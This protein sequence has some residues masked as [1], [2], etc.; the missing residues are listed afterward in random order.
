MFAKGATPVDAV[1]LGANQVDRI[2]KGADAVYD[3]ASGGD[4]AVTPQIR[5][6]SLTVNASGSS[7]TIPIPAGAV[8]GDTI[9]AFVSGGYTPSLMSG[10]T[11]VNF[12]TGTNWNGRIQ[13]KVLTSADIAAGTQTYSFNNTYS[14]SIWLVVMVG[15]VG[16]RSVEATRNGGGATTRTV[17]E[18]D[19]TPQVGDL[20][21]FFG[22]TR[23]LSTTVV[24]LN[25]GTA[26]TDNMMA[27]NVAARGFREVL[28][29]AGSQSA[30]VSYT[31]AGNGDYQAL[32][33]LN[34]L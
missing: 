28:A 31:P 11:N 4:P 14:S 32:L 29:T 21:L 13:S 7:I 2:Y 15:S 8:A 16:V 12:L 19:T 27:S 34:S 5:G 10:Y 17:S 6:S 22:S 9:F 24:T 1:Y 23:R 26:D 18:A 30:I 33:V 25:R 20:L 3:S